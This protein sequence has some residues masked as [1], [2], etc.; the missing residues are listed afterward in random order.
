MQEELLALEQLEEETP[1]IQNQML[2]KSW[3]ISELLKISEEE[4][5][6]WK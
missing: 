2:R 5:L 3:L 1:F 6:Y 4:E